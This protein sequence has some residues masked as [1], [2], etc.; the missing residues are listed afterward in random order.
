MLTGK[1][2]VQVWKKDEEAKIV[3]SDPGIPLTVQITSVWQQLCNTITLPHVPVWTSLLTFGAAY[4]RTKQVS[5]KIPANSSVIVGII[6]KTTGLKAFYQK[7]L[8]P[9]TV[10]PRVKLNPKIIIN[11]SSQSLSESCTIPSSDCMAQTN[12][13]TL[14]T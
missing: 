11:K 10:N 3:E 2:P 9:D 4:D 5:C 7:M 14:P 13:Y 12:T 6:K 8:P 1:I